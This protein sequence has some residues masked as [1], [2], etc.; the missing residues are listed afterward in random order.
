MV[1]ISG[2]GLDNTQNKISGGLL[3]IYLALYHS[4]FIQNHQGSSPGGLRGTPP[5]GKI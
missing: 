1:I 3:E 4:V 2:G 5:L